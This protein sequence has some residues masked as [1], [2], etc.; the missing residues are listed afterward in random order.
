MADIIKIPAMLALM[1]II[2]PSSGAAFLSVT[3]F[4]LIWHWN[5]Y[6]RAAMFLKER[7][8]FTLSVQLAEIQNTLESLRLSFN[9]DTPAT[10]A[11][12]MASCFIYVLPVLFVYICI[13]T[14][15]VKS[16]DRV[17]ITG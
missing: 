12:I 15:F 10:V 9:T 14:K 2:I 16:I 3:I 5:D 13:Q 17:G 11:I 4:S 6:F 7:S 8:N 1:K